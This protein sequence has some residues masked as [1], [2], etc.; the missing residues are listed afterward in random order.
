MSMGT[1][2]GLL[3]ALRAGLLRRRSSADSLAATPVS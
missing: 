2:L 3:A 1:G